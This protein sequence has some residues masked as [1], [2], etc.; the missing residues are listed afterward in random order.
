M[1]HAVPD[2]PHE[3]ELGS[4]TEI[5]DEIR[6]NTHPSWKKSL[7]QGLIYGAG[8]VIGSIVGIALLGWL[9][10]TFGVI[11]GFNVISDRLLQILQSKY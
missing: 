9:L 5:L 1:E 8:V 3:E 7:F 10:A 11:P 2:E 4:V 6:D